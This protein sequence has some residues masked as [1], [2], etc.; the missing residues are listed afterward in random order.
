MIAHLSNWVILLVKEMWTSSLKIIVTHDHYSFCLLELPRNRS[1]SKKRKILWN[2]MMLI[3]VVDEGWIE[4]L[5]F[6]SN[7]RHIRIYFMIGVLQYKSLYVMIAISQNLMTMI[8]ELR[9]SY[10]FQHSHRQHPS[11]V[12]VIT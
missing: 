5:N 3:F 7:L 2:C 10:R 8:K 1:S 4:M 6:H 9:A 12:Y 11:F